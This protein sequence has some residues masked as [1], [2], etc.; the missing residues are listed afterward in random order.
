MFVGLEGFTSLFSLICFDMKTN[1]VK[2]IDIYTIVIQSLSPLTWL[3]ISCVCK[4]L[5]LFISQ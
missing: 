2:S 3:I 1:S 5:F 4:S